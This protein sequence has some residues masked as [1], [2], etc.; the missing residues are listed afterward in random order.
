MED[1][2][3]QFRLWS[4]M[5]GVRLWLVGNNGRIILDSAGKG[6]EFSLLE[7]DASLLEKTFRENVYF[8]GIM[9]EPMLCVTVPVIMVLMYTPTAIFQVYTIR[10]ILK[11]LLIMKRSTVTYL[12]A[13][14]IL[15]VS[16]S[17]VNP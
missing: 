3:D 10:R 13:A 15:R 14:L 12:T 11:R 16:S 1:L 8:R 9:S 17:L 4:D 6:N 5:T 2:S 7:A